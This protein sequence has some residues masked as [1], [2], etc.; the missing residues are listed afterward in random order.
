MPHWNRQ[1]LKRLYTSLG[2]ASC[3]AT[4]AVLSVVFRSSSFNTALPFCFLAII[5][6]VAIR[7]GVLAGVLGTI[8]AEAIFA[9]FMF[10][11]LH[12]LAVQ[13]HAGR[14]SLLWMFF[15]GLV[16][17]ELFGH[18]PPNR[19]KRDLHRPAGL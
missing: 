8:F 9:F 13:S 5:L 7:F 6:L 12:S 16:L 10:E 17:S 15:G 1:V 11:P 3:M 18:Q 14:N 4:A 19:G 2:V